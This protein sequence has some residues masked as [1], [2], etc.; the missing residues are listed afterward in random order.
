MFIG[1]RSVN[2]MMKKKIKLPK[3]QGMFKFSKTKTI[4]EILNTWF[5]N[6]LNTIT[7]SKHVTESNSN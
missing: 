7:L 4:I 6:L 3:P 2:E 1:I 5:P